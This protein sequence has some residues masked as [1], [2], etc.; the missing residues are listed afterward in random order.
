MKQKPKFVTK[1]F[2]AI[3]GYADIKAE[4]KQQAHNLSQ[5]TRTIIKPLIEQHNGVWMHE[6]NGE[7]FANFKLPED[8]VK[9]AVAL[10]QEMSGK[11]DL[12]LRIG[13]HTGDIK[14]GIGT[15]DI[16]ASKL[17]GAAT[18]GGICISGKVYASI[19]NTTDIKAEYL[20]DVKPAGVEHAVSVY[21]LDVP[22]L[23]G[24]ATVDSKNNHEDKESAKPSIAVLPFVDMSPG[25]DQEYF[26]DGMAEEI[27][28][29]LTHIEDLKV[30]ARTSSFQFPGKGYDINE[31]VEKLHIDTILEGSVRKAGNRLRITAQLIKVDDLSH[32]WSEKFDR[33]LDDIFAIQDE[34]SLAI[35]EAMKIKLLKKEKEAIV[36]HYTTN[37]EAYELYLLGMH[38]VLENFTVERIHRASDYF[39]KAYEKDPNFALTHIGLAWNYIWSAFFEFLTPHE[40]W[41]KAHEEIIKA[42]SIDTTISLAHSS[43]GVILEFYYWDWSSADKEYRLEIELNP[44]NAFSHYFYAEYLIIIGNYD[45][46]LEEMTIAH[47]LDPLNIALY[48]QTM[49]IY[50]LLGRPDD[51]MKYYNKAVRINPDYNLTYRAL[52]QF[53][54]SKGD[55]D[56]ALEAFF[57]IKAIAGEL[58]QTDGWIA[59]TYGRMGERKKAEEILEVLLERSKK[60]FVQSLPIA[61]IYIGL[62]DY[63]LAFERLEMALEEHD[64]HLVLITFWPDMDPIRSDPRFKAL[65][66]KMGLPED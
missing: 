66:K 11:P 53:Y 46:A 13:I 40:A 21:F 2:A 42:L 48:Y 51:V 52:G 4:N 3:D 65:L 50:C 6:K 61:S 28:N 9:C 34:I 54:L 55:F 64:A 26:C 33:E 22:G 49:N 16:V 43:L 37:T 17:A 39:K 58:T 8:A 19:Q 63:D 29:A 31:I 56:R 38:T 25:K 23:P 45:R 10:Q 7:I 27:I 5:S 15:G 57:K 47:E 36:K 60:E 44:G 62:E 14:S 12:K 18:L 35:V 41:P 24:R 59:H 20:K 32:L 1:M 30:I